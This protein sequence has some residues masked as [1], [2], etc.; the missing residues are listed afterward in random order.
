MRILVSRS[1]RRIVRMDNV[2]AFPARGRAGN[3]STS[4][5]F[6]SKM[7]RPITVGDFLSRVACAFLGHSWSAWYVI[8]EYGLR[9]P[10][11]PDEL[12]YR[13]CNCCPLFTIRVPS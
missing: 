2:V 6:E 3:V 4:F 11:P 9:V 7:R 12:A 5:R 1:K 8:D 13:E 10:A